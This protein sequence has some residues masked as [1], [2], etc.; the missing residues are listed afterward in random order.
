MVHRLFVFGHE[1]RGVEPLE[2]LL[3]F[4]KIYK[5]NQKF[6][7]QSYFIS[8]RCTFK[9]NFASLKVEHIS[10]LDAYFKIDFAA[11]CTIQLAIGRLQRAVAINF[12]AFFEPSQANG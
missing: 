2:Q 10:V 7:S 3:I 11:L 9:S 4:Y 5:K 12:Y 6:L 1:R 8:I